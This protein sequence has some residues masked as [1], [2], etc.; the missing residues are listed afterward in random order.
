MI[1]HPAQSMKRQKFMEIVGNL[2]D[3]RWKSR[4]SGNSCKR[5][6]IR[7]SWIF[8][9][10]SIGTIGVDSLTVKKN[11]C[12]PSGTGI[13][14]ER[15]LYVLNTEFILLINQTVLAGRTF[16]RVNNLTAE[17]NYHYCHRRGEPS[18]KNGPCVAAQK[19]AELL[20]SCHFTQTPP[21]WPLLLNSVLTNSTPDRVPK[22]QRLDVTVSEKQHLIGRS[23]R[24]IFFV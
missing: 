14:G 19:D 11:L 1:S 12:R 13:A 7:T 24:L 2:D 5:Y 3:R 22:L 17:R 18:E 10:S 6:P 20:D 21:R 8:L 23:S 9:F 15:V 4:H 16:R